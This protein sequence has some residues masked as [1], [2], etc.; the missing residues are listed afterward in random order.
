MS[1]KLWILAPA[2]AKSH[3][4]DRPGALPPELAAPAGALPCEMLPPGLA[5]EAP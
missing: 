2:A 3:C 1:T 4:I 5:L